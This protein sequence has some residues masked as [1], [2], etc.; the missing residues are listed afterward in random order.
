MQTG[1]SRNHFLTGLAA[2]L[3]LVSGVA[4]GARPLANTAASATKKHAAEVVDIELLTWPEIYKAIHEEGKTTALLF[5][6][7][8]EQRGPQ[9]VTGA[10]NFIAHAT[11]DAIAR[12]LGNALVAP[13]LPFSV[14]RASAD[15]PGTIGIN[16]QVFA[17]INEQV[18]EQLIINGFKNVI[19]LGDH[20]GGQK[21]LKDVASKLDAKYA[22]QGVHVFYSDGPYTKAND[23]FFAWLDKNGY[24]P[25]THAGIPDTSEML[26]LEGDQPWIRKE[27]LPTAL[28][29]APRKP[30]S[31]PD[32]NVKLIH[33]G[34]SGD[35]RR[36]SF[37]LGKRFIDLKVDYGVQQIQELVAHGSDAQAK[38][39][40]SAGTR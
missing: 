24:P 12:K 40:A 23:A 31:T 16:G 4:A 27:L 34:I 13:V 5:N 26:Y 6:G 2:S 8:T 19:L 14:N 28:G 20:G 17:E 39:D 37:E 3:L 22:P 7:G 29:D 36:S 21:E 32:P 9:G 30:G 11:A 10:H 15:L 25:S 1:L 35:A 38:P 18:A 33:N